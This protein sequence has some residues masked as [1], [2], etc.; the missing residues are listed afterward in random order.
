MTTPHDLFFTRTAMDPATVQRI[1]SESL[2]G[3]DDGELFLE[4]RQS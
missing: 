3:M 1:V 4:Y 2:Q